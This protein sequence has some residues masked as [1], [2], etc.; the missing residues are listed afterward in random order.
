[1]RWKGCAGL[2][3][4]SRK[5]KPRNLF[6]RRDS[7]A[8][9]WVC[10]ESPELEVYC[11][12]PLFKPPITKITIEMTIPGTRAVSGLVAEMSTPSNI[13]LIGEETIKL[14]NNTDSICARNVIGA[15]SCTVARTIV[16]VDPM[17]SP[18]AKIIT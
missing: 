2:I 18:Q 13:E 14:N 16:V 3:S 10:R 9:S 5:T 7:S 12:K 11:H 8:G 4:L 6:Y 17:F 1:M 15:S